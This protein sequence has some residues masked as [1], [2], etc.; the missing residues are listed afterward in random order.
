M[1]ETFATETDSVINDIDPD[2]DE[3]GIEKE[4]SARGD[5]IIDPYD[6]ELI[7]I[8]PTNIVVEQIISRIKFDEIDLAPDF[9]RQKGIWTPK[10]KSRLIESLLLRIPIPVFYVAADS[11]EVWSVVDGVQRMSTIDD[12][13]NDRF[14]LT[15]IQYLYNFEGCFHADLPRRMQRRIS[16]TQLVV[17]VI[18]PGTPEDVK[19]DVF[20][21][22]NTLGS[23]LSAQEIRHALHPDPVRSLLKDLAN[24]REF[25]NATHKSVKSTRMRDRE[26]VLRFLAFHIG[27]PEQY[28]NKSL[29]GFLGAAMRKINHMDGS[30][31]DILS[32]DFRRAM[33][34]AH[35]IF[36]E[37]AFRKRYKHNDRKRPVNTALFETWGVHLARCTTDQL[38]NLIKRKRQVV[39]RSI[40]LLKSDA[41][42]E[43]AVSASTGTPS[44]VQ[45]RFSSVGDLLKEF[46]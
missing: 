33:H 37:Y 6:P 13:V 15:G 1:I 40:K 23:P 25:I 24:S 27:E 4:R 9:Q 2:E 41:E 29:D 35:R 19:I 18:E 45:K 16:E 7:R 10:N 8:R 20:R 22:I 44:R 28:A 43:D 38:A 42:F 34:A 12:Y 26:F 11:N 30:T 39:S 21:R 17:N 46:V 31:R 3:D 14:K 36:G 5:K 32:H